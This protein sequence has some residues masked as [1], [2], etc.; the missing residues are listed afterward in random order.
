MRQ[1]AELM[2]AAST[3]Y[4]AF[5]GASS[6]VPFPAFTNAADKATA[7]QTQAKATRHL[8]T[9]IGA[10]M[11]SML[12][13]A[14]AAADDDDDD[15]DGSGGGK[16]SKRAKK[17]AARALADAQQANRDAKKLKANGGGGGGGGGGRRRRR[18]RQHR[19]PGDLA[20]RVDVTGDS[21]YVPL[22]EGPGPERQDA[23]HQKVRRRR[24]QERAHRRRRQGRQRSKLCVPFQF[25]YALSTTFTDDDKRLAH[26][27]RFCNNP[28]HQHHNSV[29]ASAHEQLPG[30]DRA[31]LIRHES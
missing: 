26:A 20:E 15:D 22:A 6:C 9:S 3:R 1:I 31:M 23:S 7:M 5:I 10:C 25:M 30:L 16:L 2:N 14:A 27:H 4:R 17:K 19:R 18:R 11:P 29:T 28:R 12:H 8:V 13:G 21:R 24:H